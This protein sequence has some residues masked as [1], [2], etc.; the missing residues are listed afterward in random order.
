M[1]WIDYEK[2]TG[3]GICVN[4]CPVDTIMAES[5]KYFIE[6]DGC[7]RCAL[8]HGICPTDAVRHDSEL[9]QPR[10]KSNIEIAKRNLEECRRCL[11]DSEAYGCLERTIKHFKREEMIARET[12]LALEKIK[13]EMEV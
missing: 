5:E 7:I 11:S 1:P 2:C 8:C 4:E 6:M 3:C 13:K 12:V 9:E 10:I